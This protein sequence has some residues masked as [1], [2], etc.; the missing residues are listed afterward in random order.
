MH[1]V[2]PSFPVSRSPL[3]T[4]FT[5]CGASV[6]AANSRVAE[7]DR[8]RGPMVERVEATEREQVTHHKGRMLNMIH[9]FVAHCFPLV[10]T[11]RTRSDPK[12]RGLFV[13]FVSLA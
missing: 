6:L 8:K 5:D 7:L 4:P 12:D 9:A 2:R 13:R 1:Q 11:A 10:S 3:D